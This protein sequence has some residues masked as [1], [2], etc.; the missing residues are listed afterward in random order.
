MRE[1]ACLQIPLLAVKT[2]QPRVGIAA[3]KRSPQFWGLLR[4]AVRTRLELAT[5]CVT[6]MYSN[7]T[8][9]PDRFHHEKDLSFFL[10]C[11]CKSTTFF[12]F[13]KEKKS[14]FPKIIH[15]RLFHK[16]LKSKLFYPPYLEYPRKTVPKYMF[17]GKFQGF[18]DND[19]AVK[20]SSDNNPQGQNLWDYLLPQNDNMS[21]KAD[22]RIPSSHH[23]AMGIVLLV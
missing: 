19:F 6:G 1:P 9:L 10:K 5:P 16:L 20:N 12:S 13:S 15:N 3:K 8:E 14:I 22:S 2:G 21:A 4:L 18:G 7:Q 17:F 11:G 23:W